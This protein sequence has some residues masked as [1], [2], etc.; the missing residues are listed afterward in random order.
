[1]QQGVHGERRRFFRIP[2]NAP[3]C[4]KTEFLESVMG[5]TSTDLSPYGIQIESDTPVSLNETVNLWPQDR[6][7]CKRAN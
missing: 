2:L 4:L 3:L 7:C 6:L 5:V 1:V